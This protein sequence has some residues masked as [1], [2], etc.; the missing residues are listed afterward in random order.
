MAFLVFL[1]PS[2][3]SS[4]I[5]L[6]HGRFLPCHFHFI[7]YLPFF[8]STIYCLSVWLRP[9]RPG[10]RGSIPGGGKDDFSSSFCVQ[11]SSGAHPASSPM[12]N[13]G[14][15]SQGKERP[16]CDTDHSP[17]LVPRSWMRMSYTSPPAPPEVCCGTAELT[18]STEKASL[19]KLQ[20]Q[21]SHLL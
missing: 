14:T 21:Y 7:I 2:Q 3:A 9:G 5:E 20:A 11:S 15:F 12:G 18:E 19:N 16:E 13:A 17:H 8:H 4:E 1:S 6:G 10:D